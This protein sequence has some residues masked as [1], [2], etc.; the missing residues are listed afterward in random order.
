MVQF[1][2]TVYAG[3]KFC[4]DTLSL[5]PG[6]QLNRRTS[7]THGLCSGG[8]KTSRHPSIPMPS[9]GKVHGGGRLHSATTLGFKNNSETI[10]CYFSDVN[11]A[12]G[13]MHYVTRSDS[14]AI[15]GP[16]AAFSTDPALQQKL[17]PLCR[18]SATPAGSIFPYG[19]DIYHRGTNLPAGYSHRY[20]V[21]ACFKAADN[22]RHAWPFH[23]TQP[24]P[25][26]STTPHQT[27]SLVL[28]LRRREM[29]SGQR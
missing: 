5:L 1:S 10:L 18:S 20:A 15:A 9:M 6:P 26:S 21:M 24:W 2:D 25:M 29:G 27:N 4:C 3:L 7:F 12:H 28:V 16:E 8:A 14:Q 22:D 19:I 13:P 23:N 11:E 17:L